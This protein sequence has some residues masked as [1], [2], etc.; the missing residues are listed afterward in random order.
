MNS[1]FEINISTFSNSSNFLKNLLLKCRKDDQFKNRTGLYEMKWNFPRRV[2]FSKSS[3]CL[4]WIFRLLL[5]FMLYYNFVDHTDFCTTSAFCASFFYH[6]NFFDY[7]SNVW[8]YSLFDKMRYSTISISIY[9]FVFDNH[10]ENL[11]HKCVKWFQNRT[12]ESNRYRHF[13]SSRLS[14]RH[15][16]L[17]P[18][19]RPNERL[20]DF[21]LYLFFLN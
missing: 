11:N 17:L 9:R 2:Y 14:Y 3:I 7:I 19:F 4:N 21:E 10:F 13:N 6:M 5:K 12:A 15:L 8:I 20:K 1:I 18:L 16:H